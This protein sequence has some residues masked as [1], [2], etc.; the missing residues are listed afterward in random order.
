MQKNILETY[1][2][3]KI[4]KVFAGYKGEHWVDDR[5]LQHNP[6][7]A[8]SKWPTTWTP[9]ENCQ[10]LIFFSEWQFTKFGAVL[11]YPSAE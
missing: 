7:L 3:E 4:K 5:A 8:A 1:K 6:G 10:G 9:A 11:I 2:V